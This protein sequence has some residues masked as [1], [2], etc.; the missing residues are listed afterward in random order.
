MSRFLAR[1]SSFVLLIAARAGGRHRP[2]PAIV[3]SAPVRVDA[4]I[5]ACRPLVI[6]RS[7]RTRAPLAGHSTELSV[8]PWGYR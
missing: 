2:S 4:V 1:L 5:S 3:S 8:L 6:K 7:I